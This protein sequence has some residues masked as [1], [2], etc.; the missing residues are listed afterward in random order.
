MPLVRGR[1][2]LRRTMSPIEGVYVP[3]FRRGR[4]DRLDEPTSPFAL[5]LSSAADPVVCLACPT[6]DRYRRCEP[7]FTLQNAQGGARVSATTGRVD[8]SVSAYRGFEPFAVYQLDVRT[9]APAAVPVI[10]ASTHGSPWS[11]RISRRC[12]ARG[13]CAARSRRSSSDSFQSAE[14]AHRAGEVDRCR[15]R[16]R[17]A[18]RRLHDQRRGAL[19]LGVVR[20]AAFGARSRRTARTDVSLI[21]SA[22]RTFAREKYRL[23]TVRRLQLRQRSA[24]VRGIG[25]ASCA[26]MSRW[27]RR[28]A[29]SPAMARIPSA[30]SPTATLFTSG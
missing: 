9:I 19:S 15:R 16:R 2:H 5:P 28:S 6:G 30:A 1:W 18:G 27:R 13:A 20:R 10:A 21:V 4:F 8:W 29:G 7:P 22:D 14:S 11:A 12:A 17:S 3:D 24:F 23:R 25:V 26:T